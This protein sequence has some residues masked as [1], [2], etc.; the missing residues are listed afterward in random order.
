MAAAEIVLDES[1]LNVPF[2]RPC[3]NDCLP[4]GGASFQ[5]LMNLNRI[6]YG[7]NQLRDSA[8]DPSIGSLSSRP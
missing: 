8:I 5:I 2:R 4:A 6:C 1:C 3:G 7:L